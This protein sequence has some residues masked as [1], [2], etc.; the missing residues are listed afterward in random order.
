MPIGQLLVTMPLDYDSMKIRLAP[1]PTRFLLGMKDYKGQY[2][3]YEVE[4]IDT[5]SNAKSN[6]YATTPILHLGIIQIILKE[7]Q[8]DTIKDDHNVGV[9]YQRYF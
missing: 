3:A 1:K 4:N 6:I 7:T 9:A 8:T 2:K 5:I